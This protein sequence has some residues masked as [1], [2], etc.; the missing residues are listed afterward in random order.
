MAADLTI[1]LPE[2][3][4]SLYAMVALLAAV[5]TGK[6][7]V[8]SLTLFTTAAAL[9]AVALMVAFRAPGGPAFEGMF[10]DDG[11]AQFAK[12]TILISAAIVLVMSHDYMKSRD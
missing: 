10:L 7:E 1:L 12:V 11:F 2:I 8:A 6:D 5:Y 4:L 9:V 3:L